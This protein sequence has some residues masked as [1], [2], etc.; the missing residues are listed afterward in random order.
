MPLH[1]CE[2]GHVNVGDRHPPRCER[3]RGRWVGAIVVALTVALGAVGCGSGDD[4][5]AG[6][7][8]TVPSSDSTSA[9]TT[10]TVAAGPVPSE[11]CGSSTHAP[12]EQQEQVLQVDAVSRRYLL[13]VPDVPDGETP[14]PLV[15]DFHGLLEG[16]DVHTAMS[17]YSALA[18]EEGFVVVFPHGTGSPLQWNLDLDDENP[19]LDYFDAV[20]DEVSSSVCVDE[21]RIYA[22]GLSMGAMFTTVLL[23][24]RAEVLA[25]AAPVAGLLDP[26]GCDPSRPVPILAFHG[27]DDPILRF[28]GGVDLSGIQVGG[29]T[30]DTTPST[31]V[32]PADLDGPGFPA[33]VAAWAERNGC[34]PDA[35]DTDLSDEVVQRVYECPPGADV[36][37]DIV[38]GGGHAWPGS[39]FSRT[40]ANVVG[41]TTFDV[42]ATRDGWAFLSQFTNPEA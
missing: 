25:A 31:T 28:N 4:G 39:E 19:D 9:L 10:T 8:T 17:G 1:A 29:Q 30:D 24:E 3:H 14:L 21:S 26:E 6:T 15:F 32:P 27:T 42:D 20:L 23:C 34:D 41:Y 37:F 5:A 38:L 7:G 40:I 13:T 35:T 12:V 2:H 33:N 36:E 16:A 11:G 22:T 18:E